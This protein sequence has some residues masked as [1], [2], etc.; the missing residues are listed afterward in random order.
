MTSAHVA[1]AGVVLNRKTFSGQVTMPLC[2]AHYVWH[3]KVM[4]L[5][6]SGVGDAE[7]I[8]QFSLEEMN[9]KFEN[10]PSYK[11]AQAVLVSAMYGSKADLEQHMRNVI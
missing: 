10:L 11:K 4:A 7:E 1:C 2:V 6:N 5:V 8:M 3:L 9:A